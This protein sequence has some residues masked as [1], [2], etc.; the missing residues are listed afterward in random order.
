MTE[1]E[2]GEVRPVWVKALHMNDWDGDPKMHGVNKIILIDKEGEEVWDWLI[3][4]DDVDFVPRGDTN[5]SKR[6]LLAAS[7]FFSAM[8]LI[9]IIITISALTM[10]GE[11]L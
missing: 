10:L 7:V 3:F 4:D 11:L 6:D 1:L 9:V 5:L 2:R 8:A